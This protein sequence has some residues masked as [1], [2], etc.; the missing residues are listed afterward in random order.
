MN[1]DPQTYVWVVLGF[2]AYAF[3]TCMIRILASQHRFS[4]EQHKRV[5]ESRQM[6]QRYL[7]LLEARR[8]GYNGIEL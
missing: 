2:L 1:G 5:L 4:I 8:S 7:N 6:R 3:L